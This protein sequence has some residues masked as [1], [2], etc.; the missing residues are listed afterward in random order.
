[1]RIGNERPAIWK[2][3]TENGDSSG[4]QPLFGRYEASQFGSPRIETEHLLLG[5]L[6]EDKAL[7]NRL[8]QPRSTFRP[9]QIQASAGVS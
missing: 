1:V 8:L 6:R 5:V 7:A 4:A 9:A 3:E 2:L